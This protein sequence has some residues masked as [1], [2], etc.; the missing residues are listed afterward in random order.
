MS[1]TAHKLRIKYGLNENPS[2]PQIE[3][4]AGIVRL[5]L[6]KS[7]PGEESGHLAAQEVFPSYGCVFCY[8]EADTILALLS[9][10]EN[11]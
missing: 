8:S 6:D 10:V 4:W 2:D 9:A 5:Y 11:K 3:K 7:K 1:T